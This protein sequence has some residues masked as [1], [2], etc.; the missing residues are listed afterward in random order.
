MLHRVFKNISIILSF[1]FLLGNSIFTFAQVDCDTST[2][3]DYGPQL[4]QIICP[5]ARVVNILLFAVGAVV[6]IML[7]IG[8][9]KMAL[10]FGDPKGLKGA[11]TTWQYVAIGGAIVVGVFAIVY[12]ISNLF[13]V[14]LRPYNLTNF[15]ANFIA[16]FS[17][18]IG[19]RPGSP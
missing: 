8:A 12:V 2:W 16:D 19:I 15:I 13:G 18:S 7:V 10:A 4:F 11:I 3:D 6:V 9:L 14:D 1:V 5:I 17:Y